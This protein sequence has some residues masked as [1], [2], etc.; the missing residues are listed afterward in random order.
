MTPSTRVRHS[1]P[2]ITPS[3]EDPAPS[4]GLCNACIEYVCSS[5]AHTHNWQRQ[6]VNDLWKKKIG[7]EWEMLQFINTWVNKS[8]MSHCFTSI[9]MTNI[10]KLA[11]L[12][13]IGD[14]EARVPDPWWKD[15]REEEPYWETVWLDLAQWSVHQPW[16]GNSRL[17]NILRVGEEFSRCVRDLP[18]ML[19]NHREW[20]TII[21][22]R[23]DIHKHSGVSLGPTTYSPSHVEWVL[24]A[25]ITGTNH[26]SLMNEDNQ[27]HL[28]FHLWCGDWK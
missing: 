14:M 23:K 17:S 26:F 22:E 28:H 11:V 8:P 1:Q 10:R 15:C 24:W 3:A 7:N 4:S 2:T 9:D 20:G 13:V 5:C 19:G 12:I 18:S 6:K 27:M 16:H 21:A 25:C